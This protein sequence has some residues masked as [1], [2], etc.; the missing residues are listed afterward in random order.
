MKYNAGRDY[1]KDNGNMIF[2]ETS[3]KNATNVDVGFNQLAKEAIKIQDEKN[4]AT[5]G[6][7]EAQAALS[8]TRNDIASMFNMLGISLTLGTCSLD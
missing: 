7:P 6:T 8:H 2:F 4:A 5:L 1:C 3:A